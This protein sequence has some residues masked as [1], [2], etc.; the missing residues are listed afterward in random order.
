MLLL[1]DYGTM[2]RGRR[3]VARHRLLHE[4]PSAGRARLGDHRHGGRSKFRTHWPTSAAVYPAGQQGAGAGL[5]VPQSRR[6]ATP[7]LRILKEAE[8]GGGGRE[9]EIERA[10]KVWS[11]GF[12]AEAI[13]RFY[14]HPGS[15]GRLG[16]A[17]QGRAAR[18]R[19]GQVAGHR[20]GAAHLRL[21]SLHRV[22]GG[23]VGAEPGHPAAARPAQGLQPR[24]RRSDQ[25]RLH[26][27]RGRGQQARLRRP[28]GLLRRSE[29]R[30]R[31]DA[32]PAVG[33]LQR[34]PPQADRSRPRPRSTSGR[35]RSRAMAA[36]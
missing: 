36:W 5:A 32:D 22:Q 9:A 28:R 33:R 31:A 21:R 35:A 12:V 27:Y 1:R 10:R 24:R 34:R 18:R 16:P 7:T 14:T 30:R 19:H 2:R 26:P 15:H 25:R 3:A 13:D 23:S 29:V 8:A 20:R 11:Q 17:Q 4:R 6:S